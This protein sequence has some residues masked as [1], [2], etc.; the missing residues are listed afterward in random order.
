MPVFI[1]KSDDIAAS[2]EAPN[3]LKDRSYRQ[4]TQARV[5]QGIAAFTQQNT[6]A[7]D[8]LTVTVKV[9]NVEQGVFRA[10]L[11]RTT[12]APIQAEDVIPMNVLIPENA[13]LEVRVKNND[14]AATHNL[15]CA[16]YF[17]RI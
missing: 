13:T 12:G 14:A 15:M 1:E 17:D 9:N 16:L 6:P 4:S 5:L 7:E 2:A 8:D 3:I 10:G 11:A